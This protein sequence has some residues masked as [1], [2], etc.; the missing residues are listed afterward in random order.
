MPK[1]IITQKNEI[2]GVWKVLE[3]NIINPDTQDKYYINRPVFSKCICTNCNQT[4]RYIRNNELKKYSTKLCKK[5][6]IEKNAKM[7]HPLIG[8]R[9][10]KLVVIDDGGFENERHY[11][12]CQ[13][14]C[15]NIIRIMDN[16][17]KTNNTGSCGKCQYHSKGEY[18]IKQLLEQNN[19]LF[20]YDSIFP[21]LLQETGRRL[22]FDF[23]IYNN[24]GTLSHFIEFDGNQHHTGMWGGSWSHL[25]TYETIQERDNIKNNFCKKHNY[26]LI[27][28]PYSKL[29]KLTINDLLYKKIK[30]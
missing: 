9:F 27:R 11:S 3:P 12:I 25:E 16:K 22:R 21:E 6:T 28:I 14:D 13:C 24:D 29:E 18:Q 17:L 5:C 23:I 7:T 30:E 10:N 2:Y 4:I 19:V 20:D 15:G 1:K 8:T 26:I